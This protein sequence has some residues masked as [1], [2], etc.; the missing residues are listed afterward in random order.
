VPIVGATGVIGC[1]KIF[2]LIEGSDVQ[3]KLSGQTHTLKK[4]R[5]KV[6]DLQ[7]FK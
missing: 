5:I 2:T 1:A 3:P 4:K 6:I 7:L